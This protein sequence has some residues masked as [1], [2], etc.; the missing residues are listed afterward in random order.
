MRGEEAAPVPGG[1]RA[2]LAA[3]LR[4]L[5]VGTGLSLA[6][7]ATRTPY[8]KS[9]WERYLNGKKPVPRQA[10][11]ALC[12][13]AGEPSA[14]LL[15]LWELADASWSGRSAEAA[16]VPEEPV[17]ELGRE[18]EPVPV[19]KKWLPY[20]LLAGGALAGAAVAVVGIAALG[21]GG[22]PGAGASPR[23]SRAVAV[24]AGCLGAQCVGR[25]PKGMGCGQS[26]AA[27][28][29][30]DRTA[31]GGQR[32][33]IRYSSVCRSVWVRASFLKVGDRVAL[34]PALADET[35]AR[36]ER[37][38][39]PPKAMRAEAVDVGD[40]TDW[41]VTPMLAPRDPSGVRACLE[42]VAGGAPECFT[43]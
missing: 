29:L 23:P 5:R 42:P 16:S 3:E 21:A 40:A 38:E 2:H 35:E 22:G 18:P 14:R 9:S 24:E 6:A 17:Y 30:V 27:S 8:S 4:E 34:Y 39:K 20:A 43:S 11:E 36:D 1:D 37:D 10:V 12:T 33:E 25:T 28:S 13:V 19:R 31:K 32:L 26:G 41:V 15:A 7:L